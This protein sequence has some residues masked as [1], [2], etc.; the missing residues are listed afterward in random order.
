MKGCIIIA[1]GKSPKK[2]E[3]KF[4]ISLGFKTVIC[5]DGGANS[6]YKLGLVPDLIIG[7]LDSINPSVLKH[8]SN[9][10]EILHYTRQNDTDVEKCLKYAIKNKFSRSVILGATGDRLDHTICNLGILL[11]FSNRINVSMMHE[12]SYLQ[13]LSG[14]NTLDAVKGETVSIYG[15]NNKT[16]ITTVGLKYPLKYAA[17]PFGERESTS[18]IALKEKIEIYITGGKVFL[19]RDFNTL[20]THGLI[21]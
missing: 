18:N 19:V 7:D 20:K 1:N 2:S 6:L 13:V 10:S 8:Y 12:S 16:K 4:F 17:L 5:A 11:K 9:K 21:S 3:I 14:R 15:F